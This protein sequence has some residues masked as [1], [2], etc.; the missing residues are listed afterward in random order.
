[1]TKYAVMIEEEFT[2]T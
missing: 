1:M 2:L